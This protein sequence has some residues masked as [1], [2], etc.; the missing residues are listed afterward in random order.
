MTKAADLAKTG[1]LV[2]SSGQ[3][4]LTTGVTGTLPATIG[5]GVDNTAIGISAGSSITTG[6]GNT[7][8][9]SNAGKAV[10]TSLNNIAIGVGALSGL[11]GLVGDFNIA[12]GNSTLAALEDATAQ[13][14]IAIG[15]EAGSLLSLGSGNVFIGDTAGQNIN[16]GSNNTF[17]GVGAG[18]GISFGGSNNVI[19]GGYDGAGIDDLSGHV[20][21]ADGVG[22]VKMHI[23]GGGAV[24]FNNISYGSSG[25][26]LVSNGSYNPPTW[27]S[28]VTGKVLQVKQ[29][30]VSSALTQTGG[31][32]S[33]WVDLSGY[34]V[35]ISPTSSS[36]KVLYQISFGAMSQSTNAIVFRLV[37]NGTI[38]GV[39]DASGSRPQATFRTMRNGDSNHTHTAPHFTFLDYPGTT[40]PVTYQLQWTG[41]GSPTIYVNRSQTDTDG[42]SYGAR[43]IST[44]TVWEIAP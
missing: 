36:S 39:G 13:S 9:G 2:N 38:V 41:E 22:N 8:F 1:S 26:V 44:M 28:P 20:V 23:D 29:T 18:S 32:W 4:D 30:V 37:R 19:I 3:I 40:S 42:Q 43:T 10:T 25:Q 27:Q 31:N 15:D 34:S 12:V 35:T 14:N 33:T 5:E 16:A 7:V 11:P 17:V 24:S 6:A 21:V